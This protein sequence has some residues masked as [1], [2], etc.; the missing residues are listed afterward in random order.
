LP[1]LVGFVIQIFDRPRLTGRLGLFR[2]LRAAKRDDI[3]LRWMNSREVPSYGHM[4]ENGATSLWEHW[5][6]DTTGG[7]LNHFM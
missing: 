6:A 2:V 5:D 7:S 3:L 1:F 4:I